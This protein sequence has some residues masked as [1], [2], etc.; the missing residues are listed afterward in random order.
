MPATTNAIRLCDLPKGYRP[1]TPYVYVARCRVCDHDF[2]DEK[3]LRRGFKR[4][5]YCSIRCG[6]RAKE[7]THILRRSNRDVT[8][9]NFLKVAAEKRL[10][11]WVPD[12]PPV[13][14][15]EW[16]KRQP[17][18][19][20]GI[21]ALD[22]LHSRRLELERMRLETERESVNRRAYE[23][24]IARLKKEAEAAR[25]REAKVLREHDERVRQAVI[26]ARSMVVPQLD[27]LAVSRLRARIHRLV[28]DVLPAMER[29]VTG[30]MP[31]TSAQAVLFRTFFNKV[32]PDAP[33]ERASK[34]AAQVES[35]SDEALLEII[36]RA[37]RA[38]IAFEAEAEAAP[39]ESAAEED[40]GDEVPVESHR[41]A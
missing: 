32:V 18:V 28:S 24:E 2:V 39:E 25:A 9:E 10:R 38:D 30:E 23:V 41:S 7:I 31:C 6:Q 40:P 34:A 21:R 27:E 33:R 37:E 20:S 16:R 5:L 17:A 26:E 29:V 4:R 11:E 14:Y 12:P 22:T 19:D 13:H 15:D 36:E 3:P 8:D 1:P 35:I